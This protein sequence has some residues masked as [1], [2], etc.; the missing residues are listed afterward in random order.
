[1][2]KELFDQQ[3]ISSPDEPNDLDRIGLGQPSVSGG[4]NLTWGYF[5]T[6][7]TNVLEFFSINIG[8]SSPSTETPSGV[9]ITQN[10]ANEE[11]TANINA[12]LDELERFAS[13]SAAIIGDTLPIPITTTEALLAFSTT[14][15]S[16]DTDIIEVDDI[17]NDI[18]VKVAGR[19]TF[20]TSLEIENNSNSTDHSVTLRTRKVSDDTLLTSR[21]IDI[22]KATTRTDFRAVFLDVAEGEEP[23]EFYISFEGSS[24][25]ELVL[26]KFETT[27]S[28]GS[29][30]G[31]ASDVN[32]K[33]S[34]NDTTTGKL[35]LKLLVGNEFTN[36]I[37]NP[38]GNENLR[39]K[40]KG[41]IYNAARTFYHSIISNATANRTLTL[42]DSDVVINKDNL[43]AT[44]APTVSNDNTE[45][46]G[47][48][49]TWIDI[50]ND[51]VYKCVDSSTSAAVWKWL[52]D[53]GGS[54]SPEWALNAI[55]AWDGTAYAPDMLLSDVDERLIDNGTTT[56]IFSNPTN[57]STTVGRKKYIVLDNSANDSAISTIT[58]DT[59]YNFAAYVRPTGLAAN[60]KYLIELF[61]NR[62]TVRCD[63]NPDE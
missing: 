8:L 1:M 21:V 61:N 38:S 15:P 35:S 22:P 33:V 39:L 60:T 45:G 32:V 20:L 16:T 44:T 48:G 31:A 6:L 52:N 63:I 18:T 29:Q 54:T 13:A 62:G 49:S 41:W 53:T 5:K 17:N 4:K 12:I 46:Y 23:I 27:L 42:P 3:L 30:A 25:T 19:Y 14:N 43:I 59:N 50:T 10:L 26:N 57:V 51:N 34:E 58:F 55:S 56:L 37:E 7:I 28:L 40:F 2:P 9:P 24:N 11:Y 47:V 36:E